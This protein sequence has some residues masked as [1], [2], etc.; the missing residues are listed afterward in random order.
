M[1]ETPLESIYK[2]VQGTQK[3]VKVT[4]WSACIAGLLTH[5]VALS[6]VLNNYDS[7]TQFPAGLGT[8]AT[9]GRWMLT[10]MEMFQVRI[11]YDYNIPF[12]NI[13]IGIILIAFSASMVVHI[14]S[15]E[16]TTHCILVGAMMEVF[17]PVTSM[18]FFTYTVPHYA[19]AIFMT[20]L[21]TCVCNKKWYGFASAIVLLACSLGIYQ[22]YL[23]IAAGLFILMIIAEVFQT[24]EKDVWTVVKKGIRYVMVLGF[25]VALYLALNSFFLKLWDIQLSNYR[26]MNEMGTL[27]FGKILASCKNTYLNTLFLSQR[28]YCGISSTIV[29]QKCYLVLAVTIVCELISLLHNRGIS[30]KCKVLGL[31]MVLILP[32]AADL[33]EIMS[34]DGYVYTLMVYGMVTLLLLP[35]VIDQKFWA[36]ISEYA[37]SKYTI[38]AKILTTMCSVATIII[39]I[40][41]TWSSNVNYTMLYYANEQTRE[42]LS[43]MATRMR[44]ADGYLEG[45]EV[46]FIGKTIE[47]SDF[48]GGGHSCHIWRE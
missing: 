14:L 36:R 25:G 3:S 38:V 23:P 6:N 26:G 46:A 7:I 15:I 18:F 48:A 34:A 45:M 33:I 16:R 22:A 44:S 24:E 42:Y 40:N 30:W 2:R 39:C 27:S 41:Y 1:L 29:T 47:D 12:F 11:W 37:H 32:L 19:L 43:T 5:F 17:P 13:L 20:V 35:V 31:V 9:S 21:S 10:L 4:F 28:N 8:G